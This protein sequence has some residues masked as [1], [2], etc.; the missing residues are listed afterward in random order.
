M[1]EEL[2]RPFHNV[3]VFVWDLL[4]ADFMKQHDAR[5]LVRGARNSIDFAYEFELSLR[6]KAIDPNIETIIIPAD[7]QY[8]A[9]RSSSIKEF[10]SF[11]AD[12]SSMVPP[13]VALALKA[14]YGEK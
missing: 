11:H 3:E 4:I 1:L 8:F 14:R 10:A 9:S 12:I 2:V 5:L 7:P 13:F 6:Y